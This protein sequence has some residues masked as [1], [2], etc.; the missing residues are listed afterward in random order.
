MKY[1]LNL[2]VRFFLL[3]PFGI[4]VGIEQGAYWTEEGANWVYRK[5]SIARREFLNWANRKLPLGSDDE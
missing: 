2:V 5:A 3:I 4:I 1:K